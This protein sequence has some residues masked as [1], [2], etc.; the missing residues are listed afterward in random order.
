MNVP[1]KIDRPAF[2]H[3]EVQGTIRTRWSEYLGGVDISVHDDADNPY[4]VLEGV[5][6]D[7]AALMGVLNNLYNFGFPLIMVIHKPISSEA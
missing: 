2:Y 5:L 7:Q 4:T 1:L 6:L 3:I